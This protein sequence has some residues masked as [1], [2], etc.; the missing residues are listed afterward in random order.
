MF[1]KIVFSQTVNT[2]IEVQFYEKVCG[3]ETYDRCVGGGVPTE[4]A[5]MVLHIET[6]AEEDVVP[7]EHATFLVVG[8]VE[9]RN[10]AVHHRLGSFYRHGNKV[11]CH[12][13]E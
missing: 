12:L 8:S 13:Q 6:K 3:A 10:V 4:R 9:R 2:S 11:T 5:V 7:E 1:L